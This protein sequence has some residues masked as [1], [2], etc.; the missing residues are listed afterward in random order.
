[1][2]IAARRQYHVT[3]QGQTITMDGPS[4]IARMYRVVRAT[5]P[6]SLSVE[7]GTID[8]EPRPPLLN[9]G[10]TPNKVHSHYGDK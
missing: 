5:V 8:D 3:V 7:L 6:T 10:R 9:A 1:M 2:H 4:D